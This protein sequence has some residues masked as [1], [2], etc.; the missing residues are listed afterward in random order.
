MGISLTIIHYVRAADVSRYRHRFPCKFETVPHSHTLAGIDAAR[1]AIVLL[2][3]FIFAV[4]D[5]HAR[6]A[7]SAKSEEKASSITPSVI[8][9]GESQAGDYPWMVALVR[10]NEPENFIA[11]FCGGTVVHPFGSLPRPIVWRV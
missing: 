5:V 2:I 1:F 10:S 4:S 8:G 9:G 7:E 6:H 11:R 3:N